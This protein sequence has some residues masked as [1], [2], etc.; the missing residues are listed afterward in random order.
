MGRQLTWPGNLLP[1]RAST[2]LNQEQEDPVYRTAIPP[3]ATLRGLEEAARRIVD[4]AERGTRDDLTAL[5][6]QYA[7]LARRACSE[8]A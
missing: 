5:D 2:A 3:T 4:V 8:P 6:G 7:R 1:P